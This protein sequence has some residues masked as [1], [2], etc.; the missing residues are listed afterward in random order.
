M[1]CVIL[2]A[3]LLT[4]CHSTPPIEGGSCINNLRQIDSAK[5]TWAITHH[6]SPNDTPTWADIHLY[7]SSAGTNALLPVCPRGGTYTIGRADEVPTCSYP[8]HALP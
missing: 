1:R 7:L 8:G 4:G 3:L 2:L 5:G 6:R